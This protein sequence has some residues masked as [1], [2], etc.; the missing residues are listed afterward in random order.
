MDAPND[1]LA[2]DRD[3]SLVTSITA[4]GTITTVA[5]VNRQ[6]LNSEDE[7]AVA[8]GNPMRSVAIILS[9]PHDMTAVFVATASTVASPPTVTI[10]T[11]K[12]STNG[13]D[14][15]WTSHSLTGLS[16][17]RA[18]KPNYRIQSMLDFLQ[19]NSSSSDVR[20]V[21]FTWSGD[22]NSQTTYVRALHLYGRPS[23]G[24]TTD[25]LA[26]WHPTS[27]A[28][29]P[30]TWFDWGNT[31][32]SSSADRQFRIKNLS[33]HLDATDID[34]YCEALTPGS[35]S[36]AAMHTFSIDGGST[37]ESALNLSRLE[38]GEIS[39]VI[40]LRRVVPANAQVS[41]FSARVA[42]DVNLWEE[43]V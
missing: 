21:R 25:R 42:A 28:R 1:R 35:P 12:D 22:F 8:L 14:G 11:S 36:V 18:V 30:H 29:L 26:L 39:D 3:G 10:E 33:T 41:V 34:L 24:A 37:F 40:T 13:L 5:A 20:A 7:A 2:Y 16:R 17:H 31:P 43:H 32:R 4:A 23:P 9:V 19:P 38:P 27:D 6:R 15:T